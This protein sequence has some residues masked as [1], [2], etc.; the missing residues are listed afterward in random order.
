MSS[1]RRDRPGAPSLVDEHERGRS[2][3][4]AAHEVVPEVADV[5]APA[6]V[7]GHVVGSHDRPRSEIGDDF[8]GRAHAQQLAPQHRDH[9]Q[10][11]VLIP[12]QAG[13]DVVEFELDPN[14]AGQTDRAHLPV[15]EVGEP[16]ATRVPARPFGKPEL[17]EQRLRAH[18]VRANRGGRSR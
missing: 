14:V 17:V 13:G 18:E 6:T 10:I 11:T 2:G 8:G 9:E 3:F 1:T 7:D 15:V 5:R 4:L 16:E 12:A